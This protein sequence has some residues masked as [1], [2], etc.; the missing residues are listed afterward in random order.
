ME[1]YEAMKN[2]TPK[3]FSEFDTVQISLNVDEET[4]KPNMKLSNYYE[5]IKMDETESLPIIAI[6]AHYDAM[7]PA[8]EFTFGVDSAGSGTIAVLE[9]GRR[10]KKMLKE[11]RSIA[12]HDVLL[13]LTSGST[14]NFEG[15]NE[16]LN[17]FDESMLKRIEF[18]LCLDSIG[19][20]NSLYLHSNSELSNQRRQQIV[21][22]LI[23]IGKISGVQ[24]KMADSIGSTNSV[25]WE[26]EIFHKRSIFA[27]T[28]S[29]L[30]NAN[31]YPY[32]S[33]QLFDNSLNT[34][35]LN[36]N[37]EIVADHLI[38]IICSFS[39]APCKGHLTLTSHSDTNYVAILTN[40][41]S[42]HPRYPSLI[43]KG[44]AQHKDFEKVLAIISS[45][46]L[47]GEMPI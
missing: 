23:D 24:I 3:L 2:L 43:A 31:R 28:L 34:T 41:F 20:G 46:C 33:S 12:Y 8:P 19:N 47:I 7:S 37:I 44:T 21:Q 1:L 6:V 38:R 15:T 35:T 22:S 9:V 11:M 30:D 14:I 42:A 27:A 10:L 25:N 18:A 5:L 13:I 39:E 36:T 26:H 32:I 16:L 45:Y 4:E 29:G 17:K 40:Y